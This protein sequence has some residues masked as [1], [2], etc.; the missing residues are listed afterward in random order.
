MPYCVKCGMKLPEDEE[1]RFCPNCGAPIREVY[2][3]VKAE[4]IRP[5]SGLKRLF[6]FSAILFLCLFVTSAGALSSVNI[7]EAKM[8]VKDFNEIEEII[9]KV[10]V[11]LIFGNNLMYCL[12]MFIPFIGPISG[13]YVL[14]STGRILAAIG[15]TVGANPLILFMSIMIFPHAWLEYISYSLAITESILLS[16][17]VVKYRFRGVR[18][19]ASNA[20]KYIAICSILLLIG[21]AIEML[22]ISTFSSTLISK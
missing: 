13:F 22:L 15:R 4:E 14:Y 16:I 11:R 20:A 17:Y 18:A 6:L 9:K 2:R 5:I 1:A 7:T 8:I 12:I 10:G 19:E 21:A 3:R